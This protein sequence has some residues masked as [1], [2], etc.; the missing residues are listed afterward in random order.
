MDVPAHSVFSRP[1]AWLP[2]VMSGAALA[3]VL[4]YVVIFGTGQRA[5][6]VQDENG[7]AHIFQILITGEAPIIVFFAV[8]WLPADW[9]MGLRILVLQAA[10][11]LLA[12]SPVYLLKM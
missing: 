12:L 7:T 4:L 1:S 6:E 5:G 11:I 8:R 2:L 3:D 10:A 9:R